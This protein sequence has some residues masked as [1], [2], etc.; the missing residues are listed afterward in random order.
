VEAVLDMGEQVMNGV[1]RYRETLGLQRGIEFLGSCEFNHDT[2]NLIVC[3][4]EAMSFDFAA[5]CHEL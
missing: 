5:I 4:P 2:T 1:L 3:I